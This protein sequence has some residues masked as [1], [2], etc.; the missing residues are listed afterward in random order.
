[1]LVSKE[2][3]STLDLIERRS[4][5]SGVK[6]LFSPCGKCVVTTN[7]KETNSY[8]ENYTGVLSIAKVK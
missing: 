3:V 2:D 1:M 5:L 4:I 6:E 8:W 7:L